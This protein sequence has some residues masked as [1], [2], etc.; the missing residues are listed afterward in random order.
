MPIPAERLPEF[1]IEANEFTSS[2]T[3]H[4]GLGAL[5]LHVGADFCCLGGLCRARIPTR[6]EG[7][8]HAASYLGR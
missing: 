1:Q 2:W 7:A 6:F 3:R 5:A 8:L 4:V